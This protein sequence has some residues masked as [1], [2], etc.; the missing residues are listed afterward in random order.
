MSQGLCP[1]CGAAVNLTAEQSEAK[2]QYC[3][4]VFTAQQAET[5]FNEVKNSK[6]GGTLLI[7]DTSREGGSYEEAID[8]NAGRC[9]E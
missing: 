6:Y 4:T 9:Q 3:D 8:C 7:A 1:S 2:C 5:Q